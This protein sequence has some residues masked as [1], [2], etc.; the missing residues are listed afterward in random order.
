[1]RARL[2]VLIRPCG[3]AALSLPGLGVQS[4]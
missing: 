2:H 1:V 4:V 3:R